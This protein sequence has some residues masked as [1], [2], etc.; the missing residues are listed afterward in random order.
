M[1]RPSQRILRNPCTGAYRILQL[2]LCFFVCMCRIGEA[3][4]PGPTHGE[5]IIGCLNP[6]G[7]LDKSHVLAQ[8]PKGHHTVWTVSETHLSAPGLSKFHK[9]LKF[10]K[11]GLQAQMGAPVPLRTQTVTAIGG[12]HRGVGFLTTTSHREMT[13]TW[14]EDAWRQNRFHVACFQMGERWVQG[15]VIY[16]VAT[17][18]QLQA[19]KLQTDEQCQHVTN[20]LLHNSQ[21]LRFI[22]GDFNQPEGGLQNMQLWVDAG[23]VNVQQW[24]FQK[25]GKEIEPTCKLRSTIDHLYVSPQLAMYLKDVEVQHDWF[26]DHSV[27]I[28]RF[29]PLGAPP[30]LPLWRKPTAIPCAEVQ[31][32]QVETNLQLPPKHEDPTKM[33]TDLMQS[34]E[35]AVDASLAQTGKPA[36]PTAAKGRATTLEIHWVRE[37]SAPVK[38]PREGEFAPTFHGLDQQHSQW[39]KQYR[40]LTNYTRLAKVEEPTAAQQQH[41]ENLW[42]SIQAA[43]SFKPGFLEWLAN[44]ANATLPSIHGYPNSADAVTLTTTFHKVLTVLEKTLNTK[45]SQA[46]KQR[47]Q[48]DPAVIFQD[49]KDD[50][51]QPVQMLIDHE[52][53]IIHDVDQE[54]VA[55]ITNKDVS[56]DLRAPLRCQNRSVSIIAAE[57]SKI[58]VDQLDGLEVGRIVE[59]ESYIGSLPELFAKFGD[60]WKQRWDRHLSA[61]E[62][63]WDPIIQFA[64]LA[65]PEPPVMEYTPITVEEWKRTLRSKSRKAATGPD[66][67]S[68]Q[69]L[70]HLPDQATQAILDLFTAVE[71]GQPWPRQLVVGIVAALA[72][73]PSA[74]KTSQFRPITILPVAFRTWSSIRAR[75]ILR[76]L[77]PYA[78]PT[79]AGNVRG[80]QALDIW[81]HIMIKV[82]LGQYAQADLTGGVVDLEKAFNML[83]R[84]PVLQFLQRLGV[85]PPILVAWSQALVHLERRFTI[86]QCVGP[87]LKSSSGFAEGCGLSVVAMLGANM[88]V[89]SYM[90]RRYPQVML[91]TYVDN[92]EVT[93]PSASEVDSAMEGLHNITEALD[94]RIDSSKSYTWSVTSAQRKELRDRDHQVKLAAKDLGGHVQY[95]Q[96]VTNS[97]I[98]RRCQQ[99]KQL[100]GRLARSTA[101]YHQKVQ[102]LRTKAWPAAL[103]GVASVHMG[104]EHFQ[105]LRTGAVQGLGEHSAGTSPIL[106]LSLVETVATDPQFHA[107]L[108][109]VSMF[110]LSYA[111]PDLAEYC[112]QELHLPKKVVVPRP[113]PVSV[114][115]ARL[116]YVAWTWSH[117]VVFQDQWGEFI[118]IWHC[119]IQEL[120]ARLTVA[121]QQNVQGQ[122]ASRKTFA[123]MERM[124]PILTT[125]SLKTLEP[126]S[127]ALLRTCLNGTFFTADRQQH[128]ERNRDQPDADKCKFCGEPDSQVHRHWRCPHFSHC[129]QLTEAQITTLL[130]LPPAVTAHGWMP[131]P[132]SLVQFQQ[133]CMG[134][135]DEHTDFI[136][137]HHIPLVLDCFTDGGCLAPTSPV[138]RLASWGFVLG[139]VEEDRF[140]PIACG[141]VPG[142]CQTALRGEIIAAVSAIK[143]ALHVK[144]P[145]RLWADNDMV[146][147]KIRKFQSHPVDIKPNQTNADLWRTLQQAVHAIGPELEVFKVNSH[148][149]HTTAK[150]EAETWLFR[151]N[152]AADHLAQTAVLSNPRV[153]HTWKQ[154]QNDLDTLHIMRNKVHQTLVAVAKE[155]VRHSE[156]RQLDRQHPCRIDVSELVETDFSFL[157]GAELTAKYDCTEGRRIA[158]WCQ[159]LCVPDEPV[160]PVSWFQL[161]ALFEF[162]TASKGVKH[163]KSKKQ[164][165]NASDQAVLPDFVARTKSFSKWLQGVAHELQNPIEPKHLRPN[166]QSI[167]FWSMCV[168]VRISK[169]NYTLMEEVLKSSAPRFL[170]VK[171][172]RC[173]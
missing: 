132:P 131:E 154:L 25:L 105:K 30:L 116:H 54:E 41:K 166:S 39:V 122:V 160:Q 148:Q 162:Q 144:R 60:E 83:P 43:K 21:G 90:L 157:V 150:D 44:H 49:L 94:M 91:W 149:D 129:R 141:L 108:A 52:Q 53:A 145:A 72:K 9:Q 56:W 125:P 7:L 38:K 36:L 127:K 45:R 121:W 98:T 153:Y 146:V 66:G 158:A 46:A 28:A 140:D 112:L 55:I 12:K 37:H 120:K 86:H 24:A 3:S 84:F 70:L 167:C 76:H 87:P 27:L 42:A 165:E 65:L 62:A 82:E 142:F 93:G 77:Q 170:N 102:S 8:L 57:E 13:A 2:I 117:G 33:Y 147:K 115:L 136:L 73:V 114:L 6:T 19:S 4:V 88:V 40:R 99:L 104:D 161:N 20:R 138:A 106:H 92:W 111:H 34:I 80:K 78:P 128:H 97:T 1:T 164:W 71:G 29:H 85:A 35:Q 75:Q 103:H 113:G 155:A 109:T 119:P 135:R 31:A 79:C 18:P 96:V 130:E 152:D 10:H 159:T 81:Y 61:D 51:A 68:R 107:L 16:G 59:Q 124:S 47:R 171:A 22:G 5:C 32:S 14:P 137:P 63:M 133:C 169:V 26:A 168:P 151:G 123:G 58:W 74:H 23:W 163:I 173:L 15:G 50:P 143:F 95:S 69:D 101:P 64:D 17:H 126:E 110:R 118:D 156:P 134:I 67:I 100:W 89:H 139:N 172:L 11:T 48:N